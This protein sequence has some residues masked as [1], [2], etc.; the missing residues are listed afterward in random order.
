MYNERATVQ[1]E[2]LPCYEFTIDK[3]M[4]GSSLEVKAFSKKPQSLNSKAFHFR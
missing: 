1:G 2:N 4:S 3:L